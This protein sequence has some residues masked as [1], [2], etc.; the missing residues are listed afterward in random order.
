MFAH[1]EV[2]GFQGWR[3]KRRRRKVKEASHRQV[4]GWGPGTTR[5][6]W[7]GGDIPAMCLSSDTRTEH[8]RPLGLCWEQM[9]DC[10]KHKPLGH[11]LNMTK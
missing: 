5:A 6:G 4:L 1:I 2:G 11:T 9:E 3:K 10:N 8:Y 7:Q